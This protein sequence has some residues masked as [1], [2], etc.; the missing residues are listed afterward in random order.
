[1]ECL[2]IVSKNFCMIIIYY[3]SNFYIFNGGN[4]KNYE[5]FSFAFD[6]TKKG[7][8]NINIIIEAFYANINAIKENENLENLIKN[9]K[10]I[11]I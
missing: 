3:I 11:E 5:L 10:I 4:L 1:M 8:E 2:K 6:L 7:S 9:A